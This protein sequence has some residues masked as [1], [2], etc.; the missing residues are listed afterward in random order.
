[1]RVTKYG[2]E[3]VY[4]VS[5]RTFHSLK[6]GQRDAIAAADLSDEEAA[7]IAAAEIPAGIVAAPER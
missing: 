5:A 1:V 7:L 6:Q 2:R 4:I 3:T